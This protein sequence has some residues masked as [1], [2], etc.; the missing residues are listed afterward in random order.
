MTGLKI[1]DIVAELIAN[2]HGQMAIRLSG[3]MVLGLTNIFKIKVQQLDEQATHA[4]ANLL[5]SQINNERVTIKKRKPRNADGEED[6]EEEKQPLEARPESLRGK[7][8]AIN[9]RADPYDQGLMDL[10]LPPTMDDPQF[11]DI[12]RMELAEAIKTMGQPDLELDASSLPDAMQSG[13]FQLTQNKS[14]SASVA[15]NHSV[16]DGE[17]GRV[18][19]APADENEL[20]LNEQLNASVAGGRAADLA[21]DNGLGLDSS[22]FSNLNN[23]SGKFGMEE[24]LDFGGA[25]DGYGAEIP[26]GEQEL[27]EAASAAPAAARR[28]AGAARDDLDAEVDAVK[29]DILNKQMALGASEKSNKKLRKTRAPTKSAAKGAYQPVVDEVTEL[30]TRTFKSWLDNTDDITHSRGRPSL[31]SQRPSLL[32]R[33]QA[34]AQAF[35]QTKDKVQPWCT[36]M[37]MPGASLG[38]ALA[39]SIRASYTMALHLPGLPYRLVAASKAADASVA[40]GTPLAHDGLDGV[41]NPDLD[42]GGGGEDAFAF[43]A[44]ATEMPDAAAEAEAEADQMGDAAEFDAADADALQAQE[45]AAEQSLNLSLQSSSGPKDPQQVADEASDADA[46]RFFGEHVNQPPS[47]ESIETGWSRR[48]VTFHK[49]LQS[50]FKSLPR[51]S[52][53]VDLHRVVEGRS[54]AT[55]A[56]CLYQTLVLASSGYVKVQ[57]EHHF[58]EIHIAKTDTFDNKKLP[59][60]PSQSQPSSSSNAE[61]TE[62]SP[63]F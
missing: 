25:D 62:M 61:D 50:Q 27:D 13:L 4:Q 6:E 14:S 57:Q 37:S 33:R 30:D 7:P 36:P 12:S 32:Q 26:L 24:G 60:V 29:S 18:S 42:F 44:D 2:K 31:L 20:D 45:N 47:R 8:H 56:A 21:S 55:A 52:T 3:D 43:G 15:D 40:P 19:P 39:A 28:S 49:K 16:Y 17:D 63:A 58:A 35:M 59:K 34:E 22:T 46:Q 53:S 9:A 10:D 1:P 54:K 51:G 38:P 23:K 41:D 11:Y 5:K 48:T